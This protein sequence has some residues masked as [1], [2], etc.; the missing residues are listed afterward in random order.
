[1]KNILKI[2]IPLTIISFSLFTKWWY[3]LPVDGTDEIMVGFPLAYKYPCCSSME[4]MIILSH[5][6]IDVLV[7]FTF[8]FVIVLIINKYLFEIK[9]SKF[10]TIPLWVIS[11][12]PL[13]FMSYIHYELGHFEWVE[14]DFYKEKEIMET[15]Y[16]F[17]WEDLEHPDY[18]KYHPEKKQ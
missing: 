14:N 3:V 4:F 12:L 1:M 17:I 11:I 5:L 16:Y 18:Y 6:I 9:S 7:Y 8:L 15:G 2:T 13:L 10:I